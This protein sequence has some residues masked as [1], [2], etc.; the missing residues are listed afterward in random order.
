[1]NKRGVYI[2]MKDFSETVTCQV[3]KSRKYHVMSLCLGEKQ[4][5]ICTSCYVI[6]RSEMNEFTEEYKNIFGLYMDEEE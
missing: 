2:R 5:A 6:L 4:T 3:C 1:M